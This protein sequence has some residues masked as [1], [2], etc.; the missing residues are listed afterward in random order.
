VERSWRDIRAFSIIGG[1]NEI[2]KNII[3][4]YMKL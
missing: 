4:K 3:A 2:M 1:T